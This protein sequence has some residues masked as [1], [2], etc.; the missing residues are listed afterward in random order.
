MKRGCQTGILSLFISVGLIA[1]KMRRLSYPDKKV[2][3]RQRSRKNNY[4]TGVFSFEPSGENRV[5]GKYQLASL[6]YQLPFNQ[7]LLYSCDI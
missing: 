3:P 2:V 6:L 1:Q 7:S 5:R 4:L